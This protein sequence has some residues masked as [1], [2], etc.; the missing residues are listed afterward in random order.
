MNNGQ[1]QTSSHI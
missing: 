1:S